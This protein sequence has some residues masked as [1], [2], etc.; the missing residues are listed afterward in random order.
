MLPPPPPRRARL[1]DSAGIGPLRRSLTSPAIST[2]VTSTET[3]V[4][5]QSPTPD[6]TMDRE[7]LRKVIT[8]EKDKTPQGQQ[9]EMQRPRPALDERRRSSDDA[10]RLLQASSP[11]NGEGEPSQQT[12]PRRGIWE[13]AK[14]GPGRLGIIS[15]LPYPEWKSPTSS[16]VSNGTPLNG[17]ITEPHDDF[18]VPSTTDT[19]PENTER[20]QV[21]AAAKIEGLGIT[22]IGPIQHSPTFAQTK[23]SS[24]DLIGAASE[25]TGTP[26]PTLM[27]RP[28]I[29]TPPATNYTIPPAPKQS[30]STEPRTPTPQQH[31]S[32]SIMGSNNSTPSRSNTGN[33][34]NTSSLDDNVSSSTP[35]T[36]PP[37]TNGDED[38]KTENTK[39]DANTSATASTSTPSPRR[40]AT[41]K[42]ALASKLLR[43][44][45]RKVSK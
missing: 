21:A 42:I 4:A 2:V 10:S 43:S 39:K 15:R 6:A 13:W 19:E 18:Q 45:D 44:A 31:R 27:F 17:T 12:H 34:E 37:S 28:D 32:D 1:Q 7:K 26:S 41:Y 3:A 25:T 22:N 23:C 8:P 11:L 9:T 30:P 38:V 24:D 29:W 20:Q 40:V 16:T 14:V 35:S 36:Q 33:T 5:K